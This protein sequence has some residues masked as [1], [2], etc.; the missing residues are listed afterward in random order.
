MYNRWSFK[1]S[2]EFSKS[3]MILSTVAAPTFALSASNPH[4]TP[5]MKKGKLPE[6]YLET[7]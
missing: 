4:H 7:Q 1:L 5:D 3:L 6:E 2:G